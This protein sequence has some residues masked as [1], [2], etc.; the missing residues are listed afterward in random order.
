[1]NNRKQSNK[2]KSVEPVKDKCFCQRCNKEVSGYSALCDTIIGK[3][4]LCESCSKS[5]D[6]GSGIL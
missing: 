4:I 5:I 6:N 2:E 1:M 3:P